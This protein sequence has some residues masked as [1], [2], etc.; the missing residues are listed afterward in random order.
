MLRRL[1]VHHQQLLPRAAVISRELGGTP[2]EC[3]HGEVVFLLVTD[4]LLDT[5]IQ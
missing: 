4:V 2:S 5:C 3:A 1:H